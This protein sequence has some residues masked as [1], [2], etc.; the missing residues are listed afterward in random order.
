MCKDCIFTL[1]FLQKLSK[2]YNFFQW[3]SLDV[4]LGACAGMLFFQR[5]LEVELTWVEYLLLA[6]AVWGIYTFDHLMDAKNIKGRASSARH[7]FHQVH[8]NKLLVWLILVGILGGYLVWNYVHFSGIITF[9]IILGLLIVGNI[10]FLK[11]Y[12][13]K[14]IFLKE[15]STAGFYTLG[16]VLAPWI[17]YTKGPFP[18]VF[19][20]MILG[21]LLMA[22][23]NLLLLSYLD[24][25]SDQ[26]DQLTSIVNSIGTGKIK[27]LLNCLVGVELV[28]LAA[29]AIYLPSYYYM[30]LVLLTIMFL[31]HAIAFF[32]PYLKKEKIR[33]RIDGIYML[34]LILLLL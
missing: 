23:F 34:P 3:L 28:Y 19:W 9:G 14:I 15:F 32:Q 8:F 5:L 25:H 4:V 1:V 22:W 29:L 6:L 7:L 10:L 26:R 33:R 27:S 24:K 20:L 13:K 17:R 16:I 11:F 2:Y 21:Y 30:H 31:V 12:G 18:T